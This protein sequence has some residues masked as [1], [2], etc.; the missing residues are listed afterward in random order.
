ME[1]D[2]KIGLILGVLLV[3]VVAVIFFRRD[4]ADRDEFAKLLPAPD[5]LADRAKEAMN[6]SACEPYPVA[7]EYLSD[8]WQ[9]S[10]PTK[11]LRTPPPERGK[12]LGP[13]EG[14][15]C[16]LSKPS[17][18]A[19]ILQ[20]PEFGPPKPTAERKTT[21]LTMLGK[22]APLDGSPRDGSGGEYVIREG[23]T[24]SSIAADLLGDAWAYRQILEANPDLIDENHIVVGQRIRIPGRAAGESRRVAETA[25]PPRRASAGAAPSRRADQHTAGERTYRVRE[26]ESLIQIARQIYGDES[27]FWKIYDAN[28]DQLTDPNVVPSGT[29]L[30]LP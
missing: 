22:Q 8:A 18:P 10:A 5:E 12:E 4:D 23:D 11:A 14:D 19:A 24:L 25:P 26:N 15:T 9:P 28:R 3:A 1:R 13:D 6:S 27:M 20:P 21:T 7:P 17:G 30:R 2:V 29:I 16:E